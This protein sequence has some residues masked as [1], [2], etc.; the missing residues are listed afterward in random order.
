MDEKTLI[1]KLLLTGHLNVAERR[2]LPK[3]Q[4]RSSLM[5][6]LF[7]E[8][9][10]GGDWFHAWWLPDDSM[11]GCTIRYRGLG[12]GQMEMSYEG[13]EG[14]WTKRFHHPSLKDAAWSLVREIREQL[15]PQLDGIPVL[16]SA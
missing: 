6:E 1:R 7:E 16:W 9:L 13:M 5:A 2:W 4:A 11:F 10:A 3:G 14:S 8:W 12:S 15:G